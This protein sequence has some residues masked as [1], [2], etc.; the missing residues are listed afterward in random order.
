METPAS[1]QGVD[2]RSFGSADELLDALCP[3]RS[4][5]GEPGDWIFRGQRDATWSL[6]PTAFRPG[7]FAAFGMDVENHW[8]SQANAQRDLLRDFLEGL[9]RA[10]VE[11]PRALPNLAV[12]PDVISILELAP[13]AF[14]VQALA[15]HHRIPTVLLDWTQRGFVA[16]YFAAAEA[17]D[18][19][20]VGAATHLAVWCL[21]KRAFPDTWG[22]FFRFAPTGANANLSAQAGL[23]TIYKENDNAPLEAHLARFRAKGVPVPMPQRW[24]LPVSQASELLRLL[25]CEGITASS[26]FPG[27]DGVVAG[28]R[29]RAYWAKRRQY[30]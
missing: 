14:P 2:D 10:E 16:A 26:M 29:E 25:A 12:D 19:E 5:W 4:A 20:K 24:M 1:V 3:R 23:F 13:H 17:A 9:N 6:M 7:A 30:P 22:R 8:N 21:E 11:V 18:P 27:A 15:Q 28:L